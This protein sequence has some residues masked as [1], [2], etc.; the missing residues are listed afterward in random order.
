[1]LVFFGIERKYFLDMP[2]GNSMPL[3]ANSGC[4]L[5]DIL[6]PWPRT[7]N[8]SWSAD[9]LFKKIKQCSDLELR[10][11]KH[12]AQ[13]VAH[14]I[15]YLEVPYSNIECATAILCECFSRADQPVCGLCFE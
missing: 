1:M 2:H 4:P 5:G 13:K 3:P 7:L 8:V 6:R 15:F 12:A 9:F 11:L 10:L 14:C